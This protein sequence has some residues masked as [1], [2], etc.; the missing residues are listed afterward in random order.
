MKAKAISI[1][2]IATSQG[3]FVAHYSEQGLAALGFPGAK[4]SSQA[5]SAPTPEIRAWH[6]LTTKAVKAIVAG[7]T[8]DEL[9]PLDVSSGTEFQ[10]RVWEELLW[11]PCG[12]TRS[13]GEVAKNIRKPKAVRAV[14]GA[15][16][17]NPIPL[18]IPCHRVLAANRKIGGFSGGLG[19]KQ[20]LLE[21]EGVEV[22]G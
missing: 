14:G 7:K 9:P 18:L 11:I 1:L 13:Y 5:T 19:W 4:S 16:G 3:T 12:E 10:Q 21:I 15:C 17:A 6:A 20:R 22:A 8:P 2:T